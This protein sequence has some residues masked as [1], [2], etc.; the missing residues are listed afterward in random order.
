MGAWGASVFEDDSSLD[1]LEGDYASG[2]AS[3]VVSAL[4]TASDT[5][6][7]GYLEVDEGAAAWAAAEV[8]ATAL[9]DLADGISPDNLELLNAHGTE[10]RDTDGIEGKAKAALDRIV[11]G[12]SE[13]NELWLESDKQSDWVAAINDL[14]RRLG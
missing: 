6:V 8:V 2:G 13:L 3:A 4:D 12:N 10:V 11:S 9:G 7:T 14:R 1:W 5:P